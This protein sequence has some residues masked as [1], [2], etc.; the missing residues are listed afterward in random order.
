MPNKIKELFFLILNIIQVRI[1]AGRLKSTRETLPFRWLKN[2]ETE[3]DGDIKRTS[4][5]ATRSF[6]CRREVAIWRRHA[7]ILKLLLPDT[8]FSARH[9]RDLLVFWLALL[10][11]KVQPFVCTTIMVKLLD[12]QERFS[13]LI[14]NS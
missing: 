12:L 5:P 8:S 1:L 11:E 2:T 6:P 9:S 14:G 13:L 10:Y 4:R 3:C 7:A